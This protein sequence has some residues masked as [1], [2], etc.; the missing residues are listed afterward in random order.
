M[1]HK[2]FFIFFFILLHSKSFCKSSKF[3]NVIKEP[4]HHTPSFYPETYDQIGYT[5]LLDTLIRWE[6]TRSMYD[7]KFGQSLSQI[8]SLS[9]ITNSDYGM[10]M[11]HYFEGIRRGLGDPLNAEN[12]FLK[13]L[14]Y[15]EAQKDTSGILHTSMHLFRLGLNT[16]MLDYG[17]LIQQYDFYQKVLGI[18]SKAK[19][20]LDEIIHLRNTILYDEY[21]CGEKNVSYYKAEIER[22]LSIIET[23]DSKYDY[24]KFLM[25]NTVGIIHS[26]SIKTVESEYYHSKAFD[27]IQ[28]YTSRELF[29]AAYRLAAMKH[30]NGKYE[31]SL[32]YL[33]LCRSYNVHQLN[34]FICVPNLESVAY[35]YRLFSENFDKTGD[36]I[37]SE[38][39]LKNS[40]TFYNYEL[41]K[42]K[43]LLYMKNMEA[44]HENELNSKIIFEN[45]RRQFKQRLGLFVTILVILLLILYTYLRSQNQ[46][47]LEKEIRHKNFIYSMIGHDLSSP[48]IDIDMILDGI[49]IDLDEKLN[50]NQKNYLNKIRTT[51][52]GANLLLKNLLNLYKKETGFYT[53]KE[54]RLLTNIKDKIDISIGHL[55]NDKLGNII[56]LENNCNADIVAFI[57]R[58]SFQCVIRNIV[59]NAIKH[60][61]CTKIIFDASIYERY[62]VI[63]IVDDGIGISDAIADIYN[64]N[65]PIQESAIDKKSRI[66]LGT[67]FILE[68]VQALKSELKVNTNKNGTAYTWRL[69]IK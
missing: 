56:H 33:N 12:D 40:F 66:G 42:Q 17:I 55:F 44:L 22:G 54:N 31:E 30:A 27:V 5:K 35:M 11:F 51:S 10:A 45:E 64:K 41:P 28:K 14:E 48:L 65:I 34:N 29:M 36:D 18:G 67:I 52:Q 43:Y 13:A 6:M 46:K 59:D 38:N 25:L 50:A 16:A 53:Q 32:H 21:I 9:H 57:D 23:L 20:P 69:P 7:W 1:I 60:S 37:N 4:L 47:K 63:N 19:T 3:L 49:I 68:F 61:K 8:K 2:V 39:N 58:P 26:K 24:Y 15:F 62:L